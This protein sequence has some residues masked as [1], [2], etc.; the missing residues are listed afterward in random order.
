MALEDLRPFFG[1]L[2]DRT[3]IEVVRF[4]AL[5]PAPRSL[6]IR[7]LGGGPRALVTAA[8]APERGLILIAREFF[9]PDTAEGLALIGHELVHQQQFEEMPDFLARYQD[10]EASRLAEQ[11][12]FWQ[13]VFELPAYQRQAEMEQEFQ[14]RGYPLTK[15]LVPREFRE[16]PGAVTEPGSFAP[17]AIFLVGAAATVAVIAAAAA[18]R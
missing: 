3:E 15:S 17:L 7:E 8:Q 4:L 11:L 18:K 2:L 13:N 16:T 5:A 14:A 6:A 12:P 10:A 9:N 1:N